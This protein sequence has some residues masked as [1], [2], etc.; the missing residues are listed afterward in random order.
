[1]FWRKTDTF[2]YLVPKRPS[3][4]SDGPSKWTKQNNNASAA[5]VATDD[6]VEWG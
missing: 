1:M 3:V 5:V 2:Q 6:G 4:L